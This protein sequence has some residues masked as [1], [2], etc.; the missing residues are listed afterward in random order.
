L[1]LA[2]TIFWAVALL[3]GLITAIMSIKNWHWAQ[4][5]LVLSIVFCSFGVLVLGLEVYRIHSK[6]RSKLPALEKQIAD[7]EAEND[8]LTYGGDAAML[9][10]IF[11]G[12][13]PVFDI[14]AERGR[15]PS[16]EAWTKRLQD[17]HRQRGR[18]WKGVQKGQIDGPTNRITV[19][20]AQQP[21]PTQNSTVYV[22]EDGEPNAA[23][24]QQ[25]AQ[26][27]GA[28]RVVE[29]RPDGAT[30]EALYTLDQ[31]TGNRLAGSQLPWTIY[32]TIPTDNYALYK[33]ATEEQLRQWLPA[34]TVDEFIRHGMPVVKPPAGAAFD[35]RVA[36][37]DEAGHRVAPDAPEA[38]KWV[39][40]RQLRDYAYLFAAANRQLVELRA[41]K[42]ALTEDIRHLTEALEISKKFVALREEE[43]EGLSGDLEHMEADRKA[44]EDHLAAVQALLKHVTERVAALEAENLGYVNE[45]R[46]RQTDALQKLPRAPSGAVSIEPGDF[47]S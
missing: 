22:F 20:I 42:D 6:I 15:M 43:K 39:F 13:V 1:D 9:N 29:V 4:M 30:L 32:E 46:Q 45:L 7:L 21:G 37:L 26:Y 47:G 27:L 2:L 23:A 5:L 40:D 31:R 17:I 3:V 18:V 44:I 28:F 16:V 34:K 11:A 10:T 36:A 38:V 24:P 41:D 8:A 12:D 14:E 33:G 19:G 35:P 25:G